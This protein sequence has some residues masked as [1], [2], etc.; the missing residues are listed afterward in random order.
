MSDETRAKISRSQRERYG[1]ERRQRA[2]LRGTLHEF[3]L[4]LSLTWDAENEDDVRDALARVDDFLAIER[5]RD[6]GYSG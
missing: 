3:A 1:R 4:W 5:T 2:D 6:D